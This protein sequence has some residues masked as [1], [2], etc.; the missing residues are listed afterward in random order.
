MNSK[1]KYIST[2]RYIFAMLV[3]SLKA[4]TGLKK[5]SNQFFISARIV[6]IF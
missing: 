5:V 4:R 3:E 1:Y 6:Q 2:R